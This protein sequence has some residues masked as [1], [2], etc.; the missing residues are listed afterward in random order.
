MELAIIRREAS[1]TFHVDC[2]DRVFV[3]VFVCMCISLCASVCLH[4]CVSMYVYACVCIYVCV[5]VYWLERTHLIAF[6]LF[7][8]RS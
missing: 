6:L 5:C 8:T 1:G 4:V 3:C 2:N 7:I